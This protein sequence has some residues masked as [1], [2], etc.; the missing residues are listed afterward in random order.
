LGGFHRKKKPPPFK[1]AISDSYNGRWKK[2][3]LKK[4]QK[5]FCRCGREKRRKATR[6]DAAFAAGKDTRKGEPVLVFF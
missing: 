6:L 5:Q 4:A 1:Q 3:A 2:L